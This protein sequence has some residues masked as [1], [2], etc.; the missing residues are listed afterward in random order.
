[1]ATGTSGGLLDERAAQSHFKHQLLVNYVVPFT[2]MTGSTAIGR[3]VV[4][5]D[6][7]A[8]RGR[9]TDG[10]AASSEI[11]LRSARKSQK[12]TIELF[13]VE[14]NRED[15]ES[16]AHVTKIYVDQGVK[17]TAS[18][19]RV[20]Q[21]LPAVIEQ[22]KDVP[23]FMFLDPTGAVL[24]FA[25]LETILACSRRSERPPTEVLLNFSADLSRRTAG[26]LLGPSGA[27][28]RYPTMDA[29]C[30]GTWWKQTVFDAHS[31][32]ASYE[33]MAH[34]IATEYAQR[35]SKAVNMHAIA[36]PVRRRVSHQPIY[37]LIFLTRN[38][39]GVWVMA[40]A[41]ARARNKWLEALGPSDIDDDGALFSFGASVK[42]RIAKDQA[43]ARTIV[44]NNL[45]TIMNNRLRLE[46]V[47]DP[48][49]VF[50][51]AYGVAL[52]TTVKQAV[53]SL[54]NRDELVH[55][56]GLKPRFRNSVIV[57]QTK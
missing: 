17:A 12:I 42:E 56:A 27:N 45:R 8:G 46:L 33:A 16:L 40:D 6:G 34:A 44:E 13:L 36:I 54:S 26:L 10:T 7:Y 32:G 30:G 20:E 37:H 19:G 53:T 51:E 21:F 28:K 1:M 29:V 55:I 39:Y 4:V 52:E 49:S 48:W 18:H 31:R 38:S 35:L 47:K 9:Y 43:E 50:G 14:K 57:R 2:A 23:L 5:L 11:L 15:F 25:E 24:P 3:R 41:V 22:A